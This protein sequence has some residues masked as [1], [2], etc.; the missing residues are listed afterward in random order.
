MVGI[1]FDYYL[2]QQ[3]YLSLKTK[4][5][6]KFCVH[7][8]PIFS[9]PVTIMSVHNYKHACIIKCVLRTNVLNYLAVCMYVRLY[10]CMY[11]CLKPL[12]YGASK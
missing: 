4:N 3:S 10:V 12:V 11:V 9:C 6:V 5:V 1:I 8:S 2:Y 7:I